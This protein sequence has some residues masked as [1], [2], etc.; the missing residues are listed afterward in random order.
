MSFEV[1]STTEELLQRRAD[2]E[3]GATWMFGEPVY[4]QEEI[5]ELH[6]I[7][8]ELDRREWDEVMKRQLIQMEIA[9]RIVDAAA[10]VRKIAG[11]QYPKKIA[12][13]KD[14]VRSVQTKHGG[15][16]L[17]AVPE[18]ERAARAKN[19]QLSAFDIAWLT[20]AAYDLTEEQ[21]KAKEGI[22]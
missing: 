4:R 2:I 3:D 12:P 11:Q 13:W 22:G 20:A 18:I 14:L 19:V 21:T 16:F 6:R 5:H 10:A 15:D 1:G 7:N 8:A 17:A 9:E